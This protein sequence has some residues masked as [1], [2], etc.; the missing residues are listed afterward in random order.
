MSALSTTLE[1]Q[2]NLQEQLPTWRARLT[3]ER[4]FLLAQ[5]FIMAAERASFPTLA[6]RDGTVALVAGTDSALVDV[7]A[8]LARMDSGDYGSCLACGQAVPAERLDVLPMTPRCGPC[9]GL[10]PS[11][12]P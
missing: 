4:E 11:P 1:N 7:N 6:D 10:A 12:R 3:E 2:T 8:A 5:R 9:H